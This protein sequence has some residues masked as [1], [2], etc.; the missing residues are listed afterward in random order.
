ML[1]TY[2]NLKTAIAAWLWRPNDT[3]LTAQVPDFIALAEAEMNR[4]IKTRRKTIRAE[5]TISA[6]FIDLPSDYDSPISFVI[7]STDPVTRLTYI[8]P[9]KATEL[10]STTY[11]SAG[12]PVYYSIVGDEFE[13]IP[14][15][16]G[17]YTGE[18]TYRQ[19]ITALSDSN[20]T[21]WVLTGHP[22]LYL[23]GALKHAAPWLQDDERIAVW[24]TFFE[25]AI[26]SLERED[27]LANYGGKLNARARSFG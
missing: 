15:P 6:E 14:A 26:Q 4:R 11:T 9:D 8:D 7:E 25:A 5:A 19:K 24:G 13:I 1:D 18:L 12:V 20:T 10:K 17:S 16:D 21:N 2:A 27:S 3:D 23:Y 22:D